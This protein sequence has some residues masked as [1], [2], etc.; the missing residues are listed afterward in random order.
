M[1]YALFGEWV[2]ER[3]EDLVRFGVPRDEAEH[4]M[5]GVECTAIA[6]E[7]KERSDNQFLLDFRRLGTKATAE[8][9]DM[10]EQGVRKKRRKLLQRVPEFGSKLRVPA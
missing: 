2:R 9:H 1:N 7:A 10:T 5:R 4:L 6:A 3:V 8:K